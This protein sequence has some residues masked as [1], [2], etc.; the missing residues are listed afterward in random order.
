MSTW[1]EERRADKAA[2]AA[3]ARKDAEFNARLARDERKQDRDE[4]RTDQIQRRRDR[5]Q[6][7]QA[8]AAKREKTLTPGNVYRR[9][10]LLLVGLSALAS[11]PAQ[12]MHFV[13]ISWMLAPIGPAV[14]GGAWVMA[15]GVAYADER[16]LPMWV[17]WLL[18][19]LSLSAAG[20]AAHINYDFGSH[21]TGLTSDQQAAAGLGLAAVTLGGPLFFEVRQWV[22]TLVEKV[23][24]PKKRAEEKARAKHER[25]RRRKFKAVAERAE[26]LMLAAPFGTLTKQEAFDRAWYDI[27]GAPPAVTDSVIS[28]RIAAEKRVADALATSELTPEQI[29][30]DLLLADL[31]GTPGGDGGPAGGTRDKGP[32]GGPRGTGG[33]STLTLPGSG[34]EGPA[35][36]GRKGKQRSGRSSQKT[37]QKPL[38]PTHIEKVRKLAELSGGADKLSARKVREV[39]GGGSNEYAVRLRDHVQNESR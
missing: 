36:L 8:R 17:R 21:L 31:F 4:K 34:A 30:V 27:E 2:E 13:A 39:I 22:I 29:A 16:K 20:F 6:R 5:A 25:G 33:G 11:L 1:R 24:D 38:D 3:E 18:R 35:G 9:G 10:T 12:I 19:G 23:R 15:A 7:R 32:Q 26:Q 37:P 28:E 14:E